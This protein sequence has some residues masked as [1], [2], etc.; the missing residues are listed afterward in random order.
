MQLRDLYAD[1]LQLYKA[2]ICAFRP[3]LQCF[4]YSLCAMTSEW[5]IR[6]LVNRVER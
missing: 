4:G 5:N 1:I 6:V 2:R 3:T